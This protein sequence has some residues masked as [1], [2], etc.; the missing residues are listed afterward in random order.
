MIWD[1]NLQTILIFG[2]VILAL[3]LII[4]GIVS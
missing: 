2:A 1:E 4:K 3:Y